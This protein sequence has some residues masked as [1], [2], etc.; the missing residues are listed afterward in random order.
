MAE[1][2]D[3]LEKLLRLRDDGIID[4]GEFDQ[5]KAD[6]LAKALGNSDAVLPVAKR[7]RPPQPVIAADP[8]ISSSAV[9]DDQSCVTEPEVVEWQRRVAALEE[10]YGG[11]AKAQQN[12]LFQIGA[13]RG[14]VRY[15]GR[16]QNIRSVVHQWGL[17][18]IAP[19][20]IAVAV[21]TM[22]SL[23]LIAILPFPIGVT[24][25]L[26]F[27]LVAITI[28][29]SIHIFAL[30]GDQPI[31]EQ[32]AIHR[33]KLAAL[34]LL[35][36]QC[37]FP[38]E[39][40]KESLNEARHRY[41]DLLRQLQS[42]RNKLLSTEWRLLRGIPFEEFL[43]EVFE[44]LGY[45]VTTTK[46]SGDQ[47]VDLILEKDGKCI[48]IQAKGYAESVGNSSVQQAHA[49]MVY[50][51]CNGCAVVTNSSFTSAATDL[52]SKIGCSLIDGSQ[53]PSLIVGQIRL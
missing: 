32:I 11:L 13:S 16:L 7:S 52:A 34:E 21:G 5:L 20:F 50:Y 51:G 15:L 39:K 24:S 43:K 1:P 37:A 12:R 33:Q 18:S 3:Q 19:I 47:G 23:L 9:E 36:S 30:P 27:G 6:L 45:Q 46:T 10:R 35:V 4:S 2:I 42:R 48:A 26:A 49:G 14:R 22:F 28:L 53:I 25:T 17:G 41:Q 40:A 29:A 8:I 44:E 38:L 31:V